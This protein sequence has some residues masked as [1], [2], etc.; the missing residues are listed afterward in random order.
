VWPGNL[1]HGVLPGA[2][3]ADAETAV[4]GDGQAARQ[5]QDGHE[6]P[7]RTTLVL[8]WWRGDPRDALPAAG[9][10]AAGPWPRGGDGS[11]GG[12]SGAGSGGDGDNGEPAWPRLMMAL[13]GAA[14]EAWAEDLRLQPGEWERAE[15]EAAASKAAGGG[16]APVEDAVAPCWVSVV[17]GGGSGGGESQTGGGG[18]GESGEGGSGGAPGGPLSAAPLPPLRFFLPDARAIAAAYPLSAGV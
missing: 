2:L 4:A 16:L 17:G 12:S 10:E 18:E 11:A 14:A 6:P 13:P 9:A 15:E 3:D 7:H 8:A 1:L 5:Q